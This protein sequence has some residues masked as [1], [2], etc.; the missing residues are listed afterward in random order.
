ME[1]TTNNLG[2]RDRSLGLVVIG[3]L[4]LLV[5]VATA[6]LGPLEMYCF[7]FFSEGGRFSYPGFGF[8][9][10]M[11][12]NIASQIIGY[13]LIAVWLIPLGYGHLRIRRWARTLS[14][15]SLGVWLVLGLPLSVLFLFILLA[16]KD[17][18]PIGVLIAVITLG[19]FYMAIPSILIR[20][21]QSQDVRSTFESRDPTSYGVE[22]IPV[23]VLVLCALYVFY[24]VVLHIPI[25]FNGLFPLFGVF[26]TGLQGI[27]LL[28]I[29]IVC[30]AIL[31]WG[32]LRLRTW[33]WW[34]SLL[35]L[36]LLTLSALLTFSMTS[37]PDVLSLMRFPPTEMEFLDG[38][39]FQGF[40]FAVF[41]G[42]PP[43]ITLGLIVFSK[44][45]FGA[46]QRVAFRSARLRQP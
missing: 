5:G 36:G 27:F 22:R 11:F 16:S 3:A 31:I 29:S 46:T 32:M 25:F 38:L 2:Y 18:S 12:G 10:F 23:P 19:L 45:Y 26:L 7:Y 6:F 35:F 34:G 39:P 28:D 42:I 41:F 40:H 43:L 21:Y 4:L 13:Y 24:A 37:Y 30:L 44:R 14:L 15:T 17:V 33:A 20:F 8:G 1:A 9:S